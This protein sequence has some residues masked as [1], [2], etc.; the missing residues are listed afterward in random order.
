MAKVIIVDRLALYTESIDI[1]NHD[2]A[3]DFLFV[4]FAYSFQIYYDFWAYS[5]IAV[6]LGRLFGIV[7]PRN[8][9]EPYLSLNP[10]EFWRRWHVTLSY[11]LRDYVYLKLGGNKKY[12]RNILIVFAAVG[13]WHGA[14]WNF[15]AWGLYHAAFVLLYTATRPFWKKIP[16]ALQIALTF[17]IVSF[18][19]PLFFLDAP[20]YRHMLSTV[21]QLNNFGFDF[22]R[23][24]HWV[25]LAI[26]AA[27]CFGMREAV[28]LYNRRP[29]FVID[30]AIVHASVLFSTAL[31][32]DWSRTFIYF[33][34]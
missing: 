6:G 14:G 24:Y 3:L 20:T 32:F 18:G 28:W 16:S 30:N 29:R 21:F 19:W 2:N 13:I 33:R 26:I 31:L 10:R 1:A 8:F 23:L 17:V 22:Y 9:R 15:L 7:L 27:W 34:F 12:A 4:I 5:T 25:F 11:W